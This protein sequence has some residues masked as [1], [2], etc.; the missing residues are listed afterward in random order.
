MWR[1]IADWNRRS[2]AWAREHWMLFC[3][4]TY[5]STFALIVAADLLIRGRVDI[6]AAVIVPFGGAIGSAISVNVRKRYDDDGP[7]PDVALMRWWSK[8]PGPSKNPDDYR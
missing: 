4:A 1:L 8:A 6:T 5:V 2:N 3:A 7:R